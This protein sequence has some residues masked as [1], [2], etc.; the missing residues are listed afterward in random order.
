MSCRLISR[1]KSMQIYSWENKYPAL[2]K[3]SRMTYNAE[4]KNLIPLY[5]REK[6]SNSREVWEK[7]L[8]Q[9]LETLEKIFR[10]IH[11]GAV[12]FCTCSA[13]N[14]YLFSHSL[15]AIQGFLQSVEF[16][17]FCSFAV[18][19]VLLFFH[20][21]CPEYSW[22]PLELGLLRLFSVVCLR[23]HILN[24]KVSLSKKWKSSP[25]F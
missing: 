8:P 15:L 23:L 11:A 10:N 2:K 20:N 1:R 14:C 22:I 21:L 7:I 24:E 13:L 5:V 6:I 25:L 3:I 12:L 4:K 16:K 9:T 18:C 19:I 17:N